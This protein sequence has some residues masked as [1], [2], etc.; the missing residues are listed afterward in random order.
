MSHR[1]GLLTAALL[2]TE[3]QLCPELDASGALGDCFAELSKSVAELGNARTILHAAALMFVYER[4]GLKLQKFQ[5][6]LAQACE[7]DELP[8]VSPTAAGHLKILFDRHEDLLPEWMALAQSYNKIV[9]D[10]S[11]I[12]LLRLGE[13]VTAYHPKIV[14][15]IGKKGRWL[16]QFNPAWDYVGGSSAE[17]EQKIPELKQAW[18]L[19]DAE[20]RTYALSNIRAIDPLFALELLSSTWKV[21]NGEDRRRFLYTLYTNLSMEDED[22]IESNALEDKRKEVRQLAQE[23]LSRLPNS[24]WSKRVRRRALECLDFAPVFTANPPLDCDKEMQRDG[25]VFKS[26]D[27]RLGEKAWWLSQVIA[28]A[29]P[30]D[31]LDEFKL[32]EQQLI[33]AFASSEWK[34]ALRTGLESAIIKY[35]DIAFAKILLTTPGAAE[36]ETAL[37]VHLDNDAKQDVVAYMAERDGFI[38]VLTGIFEITSAGI[39][40]AIIFG[41]IA[42]LIFK[43][44][45]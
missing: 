22:F 41:F 12:S 33:A 37:F 38:G 14:S 2:G 10:E 44:K 5:G 45:G 9:G 4:S 42:A 40:S 36:H 19:G 16:A 29:N 1:E 39:S 28:Q 23:L 8:Y 20:T 7:D 13:K 11:I 18:E 35:R 21:D 25:V 27:T 31:I 30:R 15:L 6:N 3:Q 34:L 43:P 24:R 32:N 26:A 17:F